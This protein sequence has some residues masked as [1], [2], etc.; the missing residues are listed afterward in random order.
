MGGTL[1]Y[2][3][4]VGRGTTAQVTVPLEVASGPLV[5]C[6]N[7]VTRNLTQELEH[8]FAPLRAGLPQTASSGSSKSSRSASAP[9]PSS[10]PSDDPQ[11]SR[12]RCLVVDDNAIAR[13]VLVT[14]LKAKKIEHAEASGGAEAIELFKSFKPNLVWCKPPCAFP[15]TDNG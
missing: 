7:P 12:V 3:S 8:L 5:R 1:R 2:R 10:R 6:D 15:F 11:Q 14:Y 9:V 13:R 4:T